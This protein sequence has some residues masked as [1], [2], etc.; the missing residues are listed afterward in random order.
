MKKSVDCLCSLLAGSLILVSCHKDDLREEVIPSEDTK[1][2]SSCNITSFRYSAP[3]G[4]G[5]QYVFQLQRNAGTGK[6]DH[7]NTAV[8]QGGAITS[9]ISLDVYYAAS[10][11]AF[12]RSGSA[13]TMV[14]VALNAQGRPAQALAGNAPDPAFLPT[15]FDYTNNRLSAMNILLA[16]HTNT[17]R[18]AY[19]GNSNCISIKDD[20]QPNGMAPGHVDYTYGNRKIH[21]QLY[22]DEPRPFSWNTFSLLQCSGLFPELNP[23][24]VRTGVQVYWINNYKAYDATLTNH[25]A[26]GGRLNSYEVS[27]AGGS[28]TYTV[29]WDCG[30]SY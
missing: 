21:Q 10:S 2:R 25:R 11:I 15:T 23:D 13:D 18:F 7:I 29:D 6:V 28:T 1:P 14:T 9:T 4:P 19:D 3:N 17:S 16:G 5:T 8:Y 30:A 20:P 22:L 24:R 12:V 26:N 27:Y